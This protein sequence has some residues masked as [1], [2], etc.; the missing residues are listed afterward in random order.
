MPA[1]L[2]LARQLWSAH[3]VMRVVPG[4]LALPRTLDL[5]RRHQLGRKRILDTALVATL[6]E[7]G[8][9]RLATFNGKDFA[10]FRGV[11]IVT[12]S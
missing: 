1:A 4:P 5:M 8:I 3:D 12:P 6:E 7:A 11:E 2:D 10:I 9:A